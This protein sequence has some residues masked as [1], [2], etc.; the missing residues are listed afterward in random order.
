VAIASER[1]GENDVGTR[2]DELLMQVTHLFGM[3]RVPELRRIAGAEPTLEV[4]R[5]RG[6]VCQQCAA[7]RQQIR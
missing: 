5:S 4:V 1:V 3:I 6:A 7:G 2:V